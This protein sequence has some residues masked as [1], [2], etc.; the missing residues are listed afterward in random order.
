M[1]DR[2]TR[3]EAFD[4]AHSHM[5][6]A[7]ELRA[8]ANRLEI[9]A[10]HHERWRRRWYDWADDEYGDVPYPSPISSDYRA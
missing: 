8:E 1:S 6:K 7:S 4:R 10:K 5:L 2:L 3:A 9:R